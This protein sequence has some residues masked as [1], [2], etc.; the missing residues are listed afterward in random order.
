MEY[1]PEDFPQALAWAYPVIYN[2]SYILIEG[3]ATVIII[4]IPAV[5]KALS[6][7]KR[8]AVEA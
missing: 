7:V 5:K 3:I 2:Y 4:S 1:M 8:M 6:Q